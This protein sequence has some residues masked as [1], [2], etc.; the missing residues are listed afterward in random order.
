[1]SIDYRIAQYRNNVYLA[2]N[3]RVEELL[4]IQ[5]H[6]PID[7]LTILTEVQTFREAIKILNETSTK[8]TY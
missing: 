2:L 3:K 8:V 1:M 6:V 7:A 4:A 5:T